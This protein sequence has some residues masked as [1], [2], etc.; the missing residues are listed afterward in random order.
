MH[1]RYNPSYDARKRVATWRKV[2]HC[3]VTPIFSYLTHEK[4][5][6]CAYRYLRFEN[7]HPTL[8]RTGLFSLLGRPA[9]IDELDAELAPFIAIPENMCVRR[10]KN[11]ES[12]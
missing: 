3:G 1:I 11:Y 5:M 10:C 9:R 12:W 2:N 8:R 6:G 7:A 4:L